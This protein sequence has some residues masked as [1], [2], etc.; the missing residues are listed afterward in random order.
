MQMQ[1]A[2]EAS[3]LLPRIRDRLIEALG[4]QRPDARLGPIS[5]L[6]KS[7]ISSRTHEE[8]AWA[9]FVKLRKAYPDWAYLAEA[10]S[11][12]VE[13]VIEGVTHAEKK[14][15]Y[16]PAALRLIIARVGRLDLSL[17]AGKSVEEAMYWLRGLPGVGCQSAAATLNFSTLNRRAMV[18]DGHVH[19]V[20]KRLGLVGRTSD[21]DQ[22]YETLMASAPEAWAAED[23]FELH[24]L[25]KGLGQSACRFDKPDCDACPLAPL[26]PRVDAEP[27]PAAEVAPFRPRPQL[28]LV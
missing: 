12:E 23:L 20:C 28:R 14:A 5:Q 25:L 6:I 15:V 13:R 19:R 16:V 8:A 1:L 24:W 3:P 9:A 7:M 17:L 22:A 27:R 26:C 11:L 2:F 21:A 10:P 4:P 18:V